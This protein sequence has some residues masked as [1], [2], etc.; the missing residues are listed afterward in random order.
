MWGCSCWA[1]STCS[2]TTLHSPAVRA[3]SLCAMASRSCSPS[4][5]AVTA[6]PA[7]TAGPGVVTS[8]EVETED[9]EFVTSWILELCALDTT[10]AHSLAKATDASRPKGAHM[11]CAVLI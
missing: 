8:L 2:W 1:W 10:D 7:A 4:S 6:S 3:S 5:T 9:G 11:T